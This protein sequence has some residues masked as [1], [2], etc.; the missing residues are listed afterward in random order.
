MRQTLGLGII[1]AVLVACQ[2]KETKRFIVEQAGPPAEGSK[3]DASVAADFTALNDLLRAE[4]PNIAVAQFIGEALGRQTNESL[5]T[6]LESVSAEDIRQLLEQIQRG[7]LL[8][9]QRYLYH[10]RDYANNRD[11][12]GR[13]A[14]DAN[15][16]DGRT[17]SLRLQVALGVSTYLRSKALDE[18][19]SSYDKQAARLAGELLRPLSA[20]LMLKNPALAKEIEKD[21]AEGISAEV[22][23]EKIT[24]GLSALETVTRT[25]RDANLSRG[26]K[27]VMLGSGILAGGIYLAVREHK[28]FKRVVGQVQNIRSKVEEVQAKYREF[29]VLSSTL[30]THAESSLANMRSFSTNI[31]DAVRELRG[32]TSDAMASAPETSGVHSRRIVDFANSRLRGQ[33]TTPVG[34]MLPDRIT[35]RMGNIDLALNR[36]ITSLGSMAS[37]LDGMIGTTR[38]MAGLLGVR[39]SA[40]TERTLD[41]VQAVAGLVSMGTKAVELFQTGGLSAAMGV[42]GGGSPLGGDGNARQ[43][44]VMDAKLDQVLENQRLMLEAQVET[45]NMIKNL[46]IMIDKY[47]ETEMGMLDE[48][49]DYALVNLEIAK[50]NLVNR[51]IRKCEQMVNYQLTSVWQ[52]SNFRNSL[53]HNI[54]HIDVLKG[55]FASRLRG[56]PGIRRLVRSNSED[57]FRECQSAF[58]KAFGSDLD[59]ENPLLSIFDSSENDNLMRFNRLM[60]LPAL[61]ALTG[62]SDASRLDLAPLHLPMRRLNDVKLKNMLLPRTGEVAES[63]PKTYYVTEHYVSVKNTE[64]YLTSLLLLYPIFEV[65]K[66]DWE[67]SVREIVSGLLNADDPSALHGGPS[68]YLLTGALRVVQSAIAQEAIIAGEPTISRIFEEHHSKMLNGQSCRSFTSYRGSAFDEEHFCALRLNPVL[69]GNYLRYALLQTV[70]A[71]P[72][73]RFLFEKAYRSGDGEQLANLLRTS[74]PVVVRGRDEAARAFIRLSATRASGQDENI[75]EVPIPRSDD[76]H[77]DGNVT[78]SDSMRRYLQMQELVILELEKVHPIRRELKGEILTQLWRFR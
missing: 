16:I 38:R 42:L 17:H 26:D 6:A 5:V 2:N 1:L 22:V 37:S 52:E 47:H 58:N 48:L 25:L 40:S 23:K 59:L 36:G 15:Q 8:T 7:N 56:L 63:A 12:L 33:A 3:L 4:R 39:L 77:V 73:K 28:E 65:P 35:Q 29:L 78:F 62:M 46:A 69:V 51:E 30:N 41:K 49:R 55:V 24:Q 13:V 45:M 61:R 74:A 53:Y 43:L 34:M 19:I 54:G 71:D 11:L 72:H 31:R 66:S 76:V 70:G 68:A 60:Y 64:R 21:V 27:N 14:V 18:I 10:G 67:K 20:E 32:L 44:A 50:S 9:R 75:I 57:D